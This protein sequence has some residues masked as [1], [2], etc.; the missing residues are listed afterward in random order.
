MLPNVRFLGLDLYMIMIFI[1]LLAAIVV[2]RVFCTLKKNPANVF[3]F[4]IIVIAVAIVLGFLSATLFQ[5]IY[6]YLASGVWK[7]KG[8]TFLGG[9]VG[10]VACFFLLYFSIGRFVFPKKEHILHFSDFA[11]CAI[12]CIVLAHAFGRIGCLFDGCC[13]GMKSEA[14]GIPM[15]I[16]GVYEKRVPTQLIECIF[17]FALFA[18]L[19]YLLLK[20]DNHYTA[21]IYLI[22]YGVFRFALEFLRD[23]PRGSSGISFISPSQLISILFVLLG[24][25]L[26]FFHKYLYPKLIEKLQPYE[27]KE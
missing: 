10:G 5:S 20:K 15:L 3:N 14:F 2:F 24:V 11:R 8:M 9:L 13:Y 1:G 22:A 25:G 18:V 27:S 23:D 4:F 26:V 21:Q 16:H 12:P 17:L 7:W 6:N 19:A